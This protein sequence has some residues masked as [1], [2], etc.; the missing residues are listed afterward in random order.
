MTLR[1]ITLIAVVALTAVACAGG[2]ETTP[3]AQPTRPDTTT[4]TTTIP[5]TTTTTVPALSVSDAPPDL[6]EV[7]EG[8]YFYATG[9]TSTAPPAPDAVVDSISAT[10]ADIPVSG[11]ATVATFKDQEIAVAELDADVFLAVDDGGGWRIVGGAWPSLSVPAYFGVG[12]R[13]VAVVG[14]DARPGQDMERTRADSIHFVA[15]DGSGGGAVVGLPRDSYVPVPGYGTRKITGSLALGGPDAMM[16]AFSELTDLPFEGYVLTGF[17]GFQELLG[18]VLGGVE[19]DVP[20]AINDRWAH[21]ALSAGR[22]MLDGAEALGFARARK[23]VPGGDFTR[24]EHQGVILLAAAS[25]VK[26]M[27]FGAIP[28]LMETAE[29]HLAT[30]LTPEQLLT[31]SAMAVAADLE[32]VDNV[33]APGSPGSAG[34]ASVVFL[35]N[36]ADDLWAD[37]A[38]G[39]L[40]DG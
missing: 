2:D 5:P 14:S 9:A 15:L 29:P 11:S 8:F 35:G 31:F 21:V 24:S 13:H 32:S 7:I 10:D 3:N 37:L 6:L 16:A 39:T 30:N 22:Q 33:V 18:T 23:T 38:D 34:G 40:E 26:G 28:G 19:V 12:P 36:S 17:A 20:F 1:L 27:G 25:T 4:T